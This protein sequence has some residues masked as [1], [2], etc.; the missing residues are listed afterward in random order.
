MAAHVFYK[1]QHAFALKQRAAV[2]RACGFVNA[3]VQ[4]DGVH[5]AIELALGDGG[6]GQLD[7]V[8]IR[9]QIAKHTA[10]PAAGGDYA[11]GSFF[12]QVFN[13]FI[14]LDRRSAHFPINGNGLHFL[15]RCH[16]A[17]VEQIAQ[18][19][20][21]GLRAQG[22]ERHDFALVHI[23]R[24]RTLGGDLQALRFAVFIKYFNSL[25]HRHLGAA[26]AGQTRREGYAGQSL[27]GQAVASATGSLTP[28]PA[29]S[30]VVPPLRTA[31]AQYLNSGILPTGS[32][33]EL[34]NSLAAAS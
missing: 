6:R 18:H 11:L 16:Q 27:H 15:R 30:R 32:S 31:T 13:A 9:H 24:Q 33:A 17:L 14:G 28:K 19:Q 22:H 5:D 29:F 12:L 25:R 21:L 10:L 7:A 20:P 26:Q 3:V 8:D 23:H 4:A 34:V 2:Y 1:H